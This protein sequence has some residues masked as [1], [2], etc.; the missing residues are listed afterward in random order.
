MAVIIIEGCDCSGKTTFANMLAEKTGYEIVKGSSFEIAE[1]GQDGMFEHMMNLLDRDNIIIDRFF[2]SNLVY[3]KLF[4]YPMMTPEQYD[5]LVDKLDSK[6]LVLYLHSPEGVVKYRM[7][8]RGD[9]MVKVEHIKSILNEYIDVFYGDFRPKFKMVFDTSVFD[10]N[11]ATAMVRE[12]IEQDMF[13]T[14][15]KCQN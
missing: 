3:G 13:K 12:I 15:I 5:R 4:N 2:Y 1:L 7:E 9:D 8:N 14:F 6:A 11:V 10:T